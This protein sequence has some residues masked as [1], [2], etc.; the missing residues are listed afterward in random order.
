MAND[1]YHPLQ[2]KASYTEDDVLGS[3]RAP[4]KLKVPGEEIEEAG[5]LMVAPNPFIEQISI[6]MPTSVEG[7]V[8]I[9]L[10]DLNGRTVV[11][12]QFEKVQKGDHIVLTDELTLVRKGLYILSLDYNGQKQRIKITRE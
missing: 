9:R 5:S 6:Y 4:F 12:K 3:I 2:G 8:I 10:V 1:T 11:Q 7:S